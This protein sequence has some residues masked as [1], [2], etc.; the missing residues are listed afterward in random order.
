MN[1][2]SQTQ[3]VEASGY[4]RRRFLLSGLPLV[5]SFS[6]R[7]DPPGQNGKPASGELL[8]DPTFRQGFALL[9]PT[10][11]KRVVQGELR[12]TAEGAKPVWDLVQWSSRHPALGSQVRLSDGSLR[13]ANPAKEVIIGPAGGDRSDLTLCVNGS[14]EY[15][16]R[17]R[18]QG[19]PWA[20]L[21]VE[22][23]ISRSPTVAELR[24]L[25][26][27]IEVRLL[28]SQLHR[29]DDYTPDL[30]A[31][32]F[33][34]FLTVQD[35]N[36]GSTGY[37]KFLWFGVPFYD[38]RYRDPPGHVARD[39]AGSDMFIYTAPS[40]EFFAG[41]AHDRGWI[42]VDQDLVPL[43]RKGLESAWQRSYL[44]E[45]RE[46]ADY[47]ITSVNLGWE[48]PGILDVGMETRGLSLR[49]VI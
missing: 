4:S 7:A 43:I 25:V 34:L 26:L 21:L 37:G 2:W 31:A 19:E 14:A 36:R 11:G 39:T 30:H 29:T 32:Q 1:H 33:Q 23:S 17:A 38:D 12:G 8:Q 44:S 10:P 3:P 24:Q 35:R 41:S 48:V 28:R 9:D 5:S 49:A 6:I 16:S 22:Q 40:G 46:L 45:S 27:R 13:Y 20:H 18:R 15:G 42:R 47:R